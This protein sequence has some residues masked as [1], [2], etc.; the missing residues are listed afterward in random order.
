MCRV[1]APAFAMVMQFRGQNKPPRKVVN[2]LSQL[3]ANHGGLQWFHKK[4]LHLSVPSHCSFTQGLLFCLATSQKH[5]DFILLSAKLLA[6]VIAWHQSPL[7]YTMPFHQSGCLLITLWSQTHCLPSATRKHT[8]SPCWLS[9]TQLILVH[10]NSLD[11]VGRAFPS[12]SH[13]VYALPNFE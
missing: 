1:I 7:P 2:S 11:L 3:G 5:C 9:C 12:T 13:F 6:S 4:L 8:F 10:T